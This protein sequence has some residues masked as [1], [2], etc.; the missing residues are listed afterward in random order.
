M[1]TWYGMN[2]VIEQNTKQEITRE[3]YIDGSTAQ[4]SRRIAEVNA[5]LKREAAEKELRRRTK[6]KQ[7]EQE[8]AE[9]AQR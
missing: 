4:W 3:L 2:E 6:L 1:K 7:Q 8:D 5:A 9:Q